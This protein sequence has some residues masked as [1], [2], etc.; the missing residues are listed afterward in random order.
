VSGSTTT[1]LPAGAPPLGDTCARL[2]DTYRSV[3]RATERLCE[4]LGAEDQAIQSMPDASPAKWHQAHTTWFFETFV[5]ARSRPDRRPF[6]PAF[7]YLFNSYYLAAGDRFPRSRR[8][9]LSRP[10]L[11]E[12][13]RYRRTVDGE[14]LDL[15]GGPPEAVEPLAGIIELGLNHEEQHQELILTDALHLFSSNPLEPAYRP[16]PGGPERAPGRGPAA[17][18]LAWIPFAAGLTEIGHGGPAF[19]FDNETP[20]HTVYLDGFLLASRLVTNGEYRRFVEDGGYRRGGLW[21]SDGWSLAQAEVWEMPLHWRRDGAE[22]RE[23]TLA[24]PRPLDDARPVCHVSYFEA[25]AYARWAGARLPTEAE[26]ER[27]SREVPA[28]GNFLESGSLRPAPAPPSPGPAQML[29]DAWE[30]TG[31]AYLPY[32]GFR[33]LPGALGEYNGKFMCGQFVL[34]GGSCATPARHIRRTYRNFFPPG[35]RWQFA[36]IRLAKGIA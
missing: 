9:L 14:M 21:L 4:P 33:P 36:G 11:D 7:P 12:V 23:M 30:W 8:G 31:S 29:G 16:E 5:L 13:R 27:A 22:F 28:G 17:R 19:A 1:V 3:R 20:R 35:A 34:R 10:T 24:G 32:P 6:H 15:L 18:P 25:D 26:W 2:L